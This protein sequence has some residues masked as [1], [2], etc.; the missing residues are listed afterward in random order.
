[1][2][3]LLTSIGSRGDIEPFLALG[4]L[5]KEQGHKVAFAA[6]IPKGFNFYPLSRR[7]IELIESEEGR[8]IMGGKASLLRKT[9]GALAPVPGRAA[10]QPPASQAAV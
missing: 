6:L 4:R 9:R 2:K 1:M 5:L 8:I 7:V 3:I 10:Y